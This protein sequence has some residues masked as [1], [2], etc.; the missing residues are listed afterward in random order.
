MRIRIGLLAGAM[1]WCC[2]AHDVALAIPPASTTSA[3]QPSAPPPLPVLPSSNFN[4]QPTLVIPT[5]VPTSKLSA[6]LPTT[7]PTVSTQSAVTGVPLPIPVRAATTAPTSAPNSSKEL[8]KV[9]VT[10]DLDT[11]RDQI[12]PSLG[13]VTYTVGPD[14]IENVPGGEDASFQQV[15]LRAPGVVE[16]SFGQFHV[17]G[18]HANVTYRV[19]G[20]LLPEPLSGFGQELDTRLIQ[21]AT[22][23]DGS[24]PAQFGF[25][26]AGIVDVTT[27]TGATLQSNEFSLYGGSNDTF[28]PS[29]QLGGSDGKFDYFITTSYNHN[30][31]GIENPTGS[32]RPLHDYTDQE[33]AFGYFAYR[34]DD[35]S[36]LTV[37][38]NA[39]YSDFQIPNTPGLTPSNMLAGHPTF[40]SANLNENQNEQEYYTVVAYQ[41]SL[42]DSA[43]QLSGFSRYGQL[44]FTPDPVGDLLFQGVASKVTN[45]FVTNGVQF[46]SSY[47]V[48]DEHTIRAGFVADY[49]TESLRTNTSV[50]PAIIGNQTSDVP[51]GIAD[52]SGNRAWE[53]GVYAQDEWKIT[54][55]LTFNYGLRYDRFD[56]NFDTEGQVSPRANLVYQIDKATIAHAGYSRFFVTPPV[57]DVRLG[58]LDKFVNTTNQPDNFLDGAPKVERSNY[59]DLGISRQVNPGWQVNLDSFYKQADN[60]I[61][62]GQFG[63]PL[64]LAPFNYKKGTVY[65]AELSTTYKVGGFST[66][67]NFSWVKTLAHDIDSQQYLIDNPE[68][69]YIMDHNIHLDHESEFTG[70]AGADYSWKN[71]RVYI[72]FLYGS[73]LRGGFAN[74][75]QVQQ[76]YPVNVGYEHIFHLDGSPKN[77][78]KFRL[79]VVNIFDEKYQIRE[80][81]GVGVE[82]PQ[83]GQRLGFYAGITY[84]F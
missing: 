73:G 20:V 83:Y 4:N 9:V 64:I 66:F 62:L 59:Y 22:L 10:S 53:S 21:S 43:F 15:L 17:R 16:D 46:D 47:T 77:T 69:D 42:T 54:P 75:H 25:H 2:V 40:N 30:D 39:S 45:S 7:R 49:T 44:A 34:F 18:E 57:Q 78:I 50:F 26:T 65:G 27:K 60:L 33:K 74:T 19:N 55:K 35:T 72:D 14:Q 48:N 31:Q 1:A 29:L 8:G 52:D 81:S 67:G 58:T 24:L 12:A 68:L 11:A 23:I 71:D 61:D 5:T 32:H 13:A 80:G 3:S 36:R 37:M 82:A 63:A 38:A 51:F 6:T 84:S 56:A 28:N 70:S 76:H 41:K 79:D